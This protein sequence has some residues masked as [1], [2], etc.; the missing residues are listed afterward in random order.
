[1]AKAKD[2]IDESNRRVEQTIKEIR[3]SQAAK[4]KTHRSRRELEKF[5]DDL[6]RQEKSLP[7]SDKPE[8][9]KEK[10]DSGFNPGAW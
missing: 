10:T 2:I 4:E 9:K 6:V 3:E 7:L 1:M 5:R 8:E